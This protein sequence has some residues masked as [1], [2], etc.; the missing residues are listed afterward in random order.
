MSDSRTSKAQNLARIRDNQRRSRARR[1]E[2]LH[3]LEIKL[4]SCEQAGIEASSEIQSAARR[5]LDENKK[6]RALLY[7]RGVSE[8][9]LVAALGGPPERSYDQISSAPTLNTMLER[10][11]PCNMLSSTSSPAPAHTRAASLPRHMP[12]VQ[13]ITVP[14]SR[15]TALSCYDSASPGSIVSSMGTPPPASYST[16]FYSTPATP[17]ASEIK[18]EGVQYDY[19]YEQA[20]NG[21]WAYSNH[22]N[23]AADP[24]PYYNSTSCVDAANIIRTMR[25]DVGPELEAGFGCRTPDQHCYVN[26]NMVFG[27]MDRYS[28]QHTRI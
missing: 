7:E 22:Y 4:R 1:K 13:S 10:R 27:M 3:E 25:S 21:S 19:P 6:L 18:T 2:Y 11:I 20:Y 26:N 9:E 16:P 24:V 23:F 28:N 14:A 8:Q 15:A 12:S 17:P 5:V